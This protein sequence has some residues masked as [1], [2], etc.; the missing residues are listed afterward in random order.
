MPGG[1]I[2]VGQR[3]KIPGLLPVSEWK[4]GTPGIS[5]GARLAVVP[6][7]I[8]NKPSGTNSSTV[9]IIGTKD[10]DT[11][12]FPCSGEWPRRATYSEGARCEYLGS[13]RLCSISYR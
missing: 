8:K 7:G 4:D 9:W 1:L 13:T 2:T 3:W 10:F 11:L 6:S 12:P 5:T